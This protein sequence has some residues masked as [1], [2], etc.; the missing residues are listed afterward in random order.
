[1][2]QRSEPTPTTRDDVGR[3]GA[4]VERD[5]RGGEARVVLLAGAYFFLILLGYYMLRPVREAMGI[6]RGWDTL[7]WL[8]TG[9]MAVM[10]LANP[11]YHWLV[12]RLPRRR[13]V[14]AAHHFFAFNILVFYVLFRVMQPEQRVG[15]G[16]AFYIWL[17]VFNLFVTSIF[18]SV[19]ADLFA[20]GRA[21]RVFGLIAVGGTLGAMGGAA[22]TKMLTTGAEL[23]SP[24]IMLMAVV[25]LE[26]A[27]ACFVL[28]AKRLPGGDRGR[29]GASKHDSPS[30]HG[31]SW[32]PTQ[33]EASAEAHDEG[34]EPSRD[35][36]AGFKLVMRSWY[37]AL[38]ATYMFLFAVTSTFLYLEQG[39]I[40]EKSFATADERIAAFATIDLWT[41]IVTLVTQLF[42]TRM[43]LTRLGVSAALAMLP[44]VT[45]GGFGVLWAHPALS[46]VMVF[47][48]ARRGLH[49]AIDRPAREVLF[50]ILG[51]DAKY[52]TKAFIDTFIYR[53]GDLIGGW[54][55]LGLAKM[56]IGSS[57]VALGLG[58]LWLIVAVVV[59]RAHWNEVRKLDAQP[60][61]PMGV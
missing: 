51:P 24:T 45:V 57:P 1:M 11:V 25:P 20:H 34:H 38:V 59:G 22:I 42:V 29:E 52:K 31:E 35:A 5:T 28:L 32:H 56:T 17:S 8:M 37:L 61:S 55:P 14:P 54:A 43:I 10:A 27:M 3:F 21:K 47:S 48:V 23:E 4:R 49:Y 60:R 16:Y 41:N 9:T 30:K 58:A 15:L 2:A 6:A 46:S 44:A 26:L 36:L 13:F 19:M 33:G 39:K 12:S 7:P 40:I 53:A 50:T 18:W